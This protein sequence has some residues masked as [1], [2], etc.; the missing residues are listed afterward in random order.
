MFVCT[1][2]ATAWP[3]IEASTWASLKL[4]LKLYHCVALARRV[5]LLR[6][7]FASVDTLSQDFPP[8]LRLFCASVSLQ[9]ESDERT[10]QTPREW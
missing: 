10:R 2:L 3:S 4:R 9:L 8:P 1:L 5:R 6:L 7:P